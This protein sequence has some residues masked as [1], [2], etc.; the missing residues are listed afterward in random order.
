MAIYPCFV[1]S[2]TS[3]PG[4]Y[5]RGGG[6]GLI[7]LFMVLI[8]GCPPL[9]LLFRNTQSRSITYSISKVISWRG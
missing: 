5:F 9:Y 2:A 4:A 1:V 7:C 6:E 3:T 8:W